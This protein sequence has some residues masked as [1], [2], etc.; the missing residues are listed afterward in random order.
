MVFN[1]KRSSDRKDWIKD[2]SAT[3]DI[4]MSK[5]SL[6]YD[7]F[8][9]GEMIHFSRYDCDRSIPNILDGNKISQR[10]VLY[11]AFKKGLEKEI[12]VAQ[13]SGYVSENSCY[14][15]GESSLNGTIICLAQN[16]VGSNN[17]NLLKPNGQFGTRLMGGKDS[18]SERYIFTQLNEIT[19]KIFIKDDQPILNYLD[20]D[21][22]K[23]EPQFYVPIV[24]TVLI[25]GALGIGTGFSTFINNYN[26]LDII[27]WLEDKLNCKE[28][29]DEFIPYYNGFKGTIEK[30]NEKFLIKGCY[31]HI[32]NKKLRI[33]ELPI[34][35]WTDDYKQ[36]LE[37]LINIDKKSKSKIVNNVTIK[38]YNDLSTDKD[39]NIE[40]EFTNDY[41]NLEKDKKDGINE[42]EKLLKLTTTTTTT[43]M[44]LFDKDN[45]LVKFDNVS[46]ILNYYY[47]VRLEYYQKRKDYILN[48]EKQELVILSNKVKYINENL[49]NTID[50]RNKSKEEINLMLS[51]KKYDVIDNDNDFKYL[52]KMTMDAVSKENVKR[53]LSEESNKKEK[54]DLLSNTTINQLWLNELNELKVAYE[55]FIDVKNKNNVDDKCQ[56]TK[57]K[58]KLKKVM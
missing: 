20:D 12:K 19:N 54:I 43:N 51:T 32:T 9:N 40:V 22:Y 15:H 48:K 16:F 10:K 2:I 5:T 27:K 55:K 24:P 33:T 29:N 17:I 3:K 36:Y 52:V 26:L 47:G 30:Q 28:T 4:D 50:L 35:T 21:G 56:I 14:H 31:D 46:D 11:C 44:H 45:N 1:K 42:L 39:V 38:D 58:L 8:I 49:N 57:K 18:A 25:N 13:F 23:V 7:E 41:T 53:L 34:G 37:T 6:S